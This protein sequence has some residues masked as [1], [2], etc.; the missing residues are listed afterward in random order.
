[1]NVLEDKDVFIMHV[2]SY[3]YAVQA[4]KIRPHS[5]TPAYYMEL[6]VNTYLE[7]ATYKDSPDDMCADSFNLSIL[8]KCL[9]SAE[10]M[11]DLN[12]FNVFTKADFEIL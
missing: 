5:E 8:N 9:H 7:V 3:L 2:A 4:I 1:M 6:F 10:M 12:V 11:L